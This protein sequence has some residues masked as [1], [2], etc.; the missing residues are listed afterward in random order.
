ME[1]EALPRRRWERMGHKESWL[2]LL[3]V[4]K[5]FGGQAQVGLE[6]LGLPLCSLDRWVGRCGLFLLM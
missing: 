6:G 1:R 3:S 4:D 5:N 2:Q